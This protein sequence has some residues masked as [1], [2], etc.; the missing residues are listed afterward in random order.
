MKHRRLLVSCIGVAAAAAAVAC[1]QDGG[2]TGGTGGSG[3]ASAGSG[4]A[5]AGTGGT[6][7]GTGG[8][9]SGTGSGGT[10]AGTGGATGAG[11]MIPTAGCGTTTW[12]AGD[13]MYTIAVDGV[14]RQYIVG[15][16]AGYNATRPQKLVFAWHGRTGT[17]MQ[18]AGRGNNGYYNLK[19]RMTDTIFVA[20]QGLG[21]DADPADTGW[22]NTNGR[23]IAFVRALLAYMGTNYC[24]DSARV[25]SVGMSYGGMMSHTIG[26]QMSE[27][28]RAIA[29]IAGAMF[30]GGRGN[31]CQTK[32][33]AAWGA[34]G[35]ADE[36]VTYASGE[37]ARNRIL[38]LNHC[39]TTTQPTTPSPCVTYDGCDSGYPVVW[40]SHDGGHT[41]PSFTGEGVALFF[42]QF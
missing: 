21:T 22:P 19:S 10:S 15:L 20:G 14:D 24:I 3:G 9:T 6:V 4:G 33:I 11:G 39:G 18:I 2:T 42:N 30:G 5:S 23:D 38:T 31:T 25:F 27:T 36:T 16:P 13:M 32:P 28:F 34:H 40:C 17:A 8:S 35:T 12:P 26:C 41:V 29:P 7:A 37:S 1:G